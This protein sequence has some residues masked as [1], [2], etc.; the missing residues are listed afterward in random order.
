MGGRGAIAPPTPWFLLPQDQWTR[1]AT[2]WLYIQIRDSSKIFFLASDTKLCRAFCAG[3][4]CTVL[5]LFLKE[6]SST[7]TTFSKKLQIPKQIPGPLLF[8]KRKID[9]WDVIKEFVKESCW[10]KQVTKG[11]LLSSGRK[12][13]QLWLSRKHISM[14]IRI[15]RN[16]FNPFCQQKLAP[17]SMCTCIQGALHIEKKNRFLL[18]ALL[19]THFSWFLHLFALA[20]VFLVIV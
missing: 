16:Y 18:L 6:H 2:Y 19:C 4:Q 8:P 3:K 11:F 10:K 13:S 7:E 15:F 1:S 9:R 12:S 14:K 20:E 5:K 17:K